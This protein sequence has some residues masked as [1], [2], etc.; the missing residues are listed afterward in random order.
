M[1]GG[2]SLLL[3]FCRYSCIFRRKVL[4]LRPIMNNLKKDFKERDVI[5][6]KTERVG[7]VFRRMFLPMLVSMVSM[8]VL[9]ITDGAFVG[10]GVCSDAL[11]AVNIVAPLYMLMSGLGLMFGIGG[12]V[13]A[14]IHFSKNNEKAANINLT[15]SLLGG[16]TLSLL[17]GVVI[18]TFPEATCRL[19]GCSEQLVPLACSYLKWVAILLP[20]NAIGYIGT[21]MIRLDGSP[22]YAMLLNMGMALSNIVLDYVNIFLLDWGLEGAGIATCF[23]FTVGNIPVLYYLLRRSQRVHLYRLRLTGKSFLLS[24]RNI[25]YQMYVGFSGLLGEAAMA[26]MMV[27]GNFMF[28][29]Y[30]GE[31]GVAAFS[32]GCYCLPIV[33]MLGNAVVQ[34]IQPVLSFAHGVGDVDRIADGRRLSLLMSCAFGL[35]GSLG[36]VLCA[37]LV[38]AT[39]LDTS[40]AAYDLCVHGLP[41]Y[42]SAFFF[43]A[44]NIVCVG[45][46]QSIERATHATLYTILR[47][48]I[49]VIPSFLLMPQWFGVDGLWIALPVAEGL[50]LL[51]AIVIKKSLMF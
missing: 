13:V 2:T 45:Y 6:F 31:D 35:V 37:P 24:L 34:S 14:S 28:M 23:S 9:N 50:T 22:R 18:L 43:I 16:V 15:Q 40:C 25:G 3:S 12:S 4:P 32:V 17:L 20:F 26:C 19:F 11:A 5:D 33:F 30:L 48:F 46:L 27:V 44:V 10:H 51:L 47:G 42:S 36:M 39:F 21:F 29:R 7:K 49:L 41:L 38:S 1:F 8:V